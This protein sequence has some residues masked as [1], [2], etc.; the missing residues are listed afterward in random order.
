MAY[1]IPQKGD[2]FQVVSPKGKTWKTTYPSEEAA[3]KAIAYIQGRFTPSDAPPAVQA[4]SP[5]DGDTSVERKK[6]G[7]PPRPGDEADTE[8]W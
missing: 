8:G 6:L 5:A 7:I 1:S 3:E 4:E 2:R